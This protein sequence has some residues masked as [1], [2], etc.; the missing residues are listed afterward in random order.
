MIIY[1]TTNL[2]NGKIYIGQD[3]KNDPKYLGGGVLIKKA[4]KKY[5]RDKFIKEIIEEC[6]TIE[7]LNLREFYWIENFNARDPIIG[8]NLEFGGKNNT[9]SP[10]T[11]KRISDARKGKKNSEE[12]N[13]KIAE[14]SSNR[15]KET[16]EKLSNSN[17]KWK[18]ENPEKWKA[19][20][21]KSQKTKSETY[22]KSEK[23]K[24]HL[25]KLHKKITG[26]GN[27]MFGKTHTEET[28]EKM[29]KSRKE[30]T[31]KNRLKF[32]V[33]ILQMSYD[34]TIIREWSGLIEIQ[35][36]FP[37]W[38]GCD[39]IIKVLNDKTRA[40]AYGYKWKLNDTVRDLEEE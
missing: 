32:E 6:S 22:W 18:K 10:E 25:D 30:R 27:G 33:P 2:I 4:I 23:G 7:Q 37:E 36:N 31:M 16:R 13:R 5:G 26:S 9:H 40:K 17:R 24:K 14:A 1:K 38:K 3:T 19:T 20:Y 29:K 28:I 15:S 39:Y 11:R 8:Y 12:H 34:D 21:S 35:N